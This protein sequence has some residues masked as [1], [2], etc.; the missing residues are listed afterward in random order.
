MAERKAFVD[1]MLS[2]PGVDVT[3]RRYFR[4]L[5]RS[6]ANCDLNG[7]IS[8]AK[9][10]LVRVTDGATKGAE[11]WACERDVQPTGAWVM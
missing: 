9:Y 11:G 2:Q 5:N 7:P 6:M 4:L 10:V 1:D 3:G 8:S